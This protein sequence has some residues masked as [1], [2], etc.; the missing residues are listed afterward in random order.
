MRRI[1]RLLE[2]AITGL[3]GLSDDAAY[4]GMD[5]LLDA[6]S[7]LAAELFGQVA[8]PLK[9]DLDIVFVDTTSTYFQCDVAEDDVETADG[10][11]ADDEVTSPV[12]GAR[13]TF[14]HSKDHRGDLPQVVIAMAVTRDG[15]PVRYWT[16][17][18]CAG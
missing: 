17:D 8:H 10:M 16:F 18:G 1:I 5:V 6:L 9:L 7:E 2:V 14:G 3:S 15:V 11:L 12:E 4:R 13:R